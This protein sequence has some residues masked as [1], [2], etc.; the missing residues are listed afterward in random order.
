MKK[1]LYILFFTVEG[2]EQ[3][4]EGSEG[5]DD[6]HDLDI[7]DD[8]KLDDDFDH[9]GKDSMDDDADEPIHELD[10]AIFSHGKPCGSG[11]KGEG[12]CVSAT[13]F[14]PMMLNDEVHE[15][16]IEET[17]IKTPFEHVG[18][19]PE[20]AE[21]L[22]LQDDMDICSHMEY[23]TAQLRRFE[24]GDSEGGDE[25]NLPEMECLPENL[26]ATLGYAKRSLIESMEM[27]ET[28]KK[29][30]GDSN[31]SKMWGHVLSTRPTTRQHGNIKIMEK[32]TAYLQ[33]KNYHPSDHT[34][35]L[36]DTMAQRVTSPKIFTFEKWW[37]EQADFKSL[38]EIVWS[39]L[40]LGKDAI[41]VWLI[42][43][44]RLRNKMKGWSA[45]IEATL[46]KKKR[47]LLQEF[48]ILDISAESERV[49]DED[50]ARMK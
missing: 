45:N 20:T 13:K 12:T 25:V 46:K 31:Q 9:N 2:F 11:S 35:L 33:K 6:G 32:A 27:A 23:C 47:E 41:D 30:K 40:V 43:S 49:I 7:V 44:K 28:E 24:M 21:M 19:F 4:G 29:M 37:L 22:P 36:L 15:Q 8:D 18:D 42:K 16:F 3:A 14:R 38:V 26:A 48:D 17:E 39:C 50:K 34:P 10:K 1:K 5:D